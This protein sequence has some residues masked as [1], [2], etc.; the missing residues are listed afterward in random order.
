M[1]ARSIDLDIRVNFFF[2]FFFLVTFKYF[3][4][5]ISCV[6]LCRDGVIVCGLM[7]HKYDLSYVVVVLKVVSILI[8]M[9]KSVTYL[10]R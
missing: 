1:V 3:M 9:G 6:E 10:N 5:L 7:G 4:S 2:F 8:Y